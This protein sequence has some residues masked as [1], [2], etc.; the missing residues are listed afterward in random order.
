MKWRMAGLG[1]GWPLAGDTG[2]GRVLGLPDRL[3]QQMR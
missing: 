3:R 1:R 2:G